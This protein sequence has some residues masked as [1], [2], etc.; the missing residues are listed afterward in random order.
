MSSESAEHRLAA[1]LSADVAGYSRLM[2]AD[3]DAT[4]RLVTFYR[5]QV[6]MLVPQHQG[7]LVDFTGDNFLAEFESAVQAT[8]C[9]IEIQRVLEARNAELPEDHKMRFRIGVHLDYIRVE[10]G[11][12]FG[13][14]VNVAARLQSQAEPGGICISGTVHE[15]IHRKLNLGYEDLGEKRVKNIPD[16]VRVFRVEMKTAAPE[17]AE[18]QLAGWLTARSAHPRR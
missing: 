18:R 12:I 11:R 9:A 2:A 16:P 17:H 1:I 15:L 5:Q 7:R 13:T 14:G 6:E 8:R 10:G 3:E 4:V